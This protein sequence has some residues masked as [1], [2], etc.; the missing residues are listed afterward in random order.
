MI[1]RRQLFSH[2]VSRACR[3]WIPDEARDQVERQVETVIIRSKSV[4]RYRDG[5]THYRVE[6]YY[7][8]DRDLMLIDV[9]LGEWYL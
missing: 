4:D 9:M 3:A 5:V 2:S 8:N 7:H 1:A 6:I